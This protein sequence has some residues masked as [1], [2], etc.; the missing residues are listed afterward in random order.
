MHP[1]VR[2]T[3]A[4]LD[5]LGVVAAADGSPVY[6]F[7]ISTLTGRPTGTVYPLLSR[8][9][10]VGWLEGAWESEHH[11]GNGPRRRYYKVTSQG[12][13]HIAVALRRRERPAP[14]RA[15]RPVEGEQSNQEAG[16]PVSVEEVAR[17]F[18]R[19]LRRLRADAGDPSLRQLS[20]RTFYSP[21]ALSEAF[22]GRSIPSEKLLEVLVRA[23]GGDP[24]EW[25]LRRSTAEQSI[26][27]GARIPFRFEDF[28][29]LGSRWVRDALREHELEPEDIEDVTQETLLATYRR[30]NAI[31]GNLRPWV[32]S[33]ARSVARIFNRTT[34]SG[35]RVPV[36]SL[37]EF[38]GAVDALPLVASDQ[39]GPGDVADEVAERSAAA[40]LLS[41]LDRRTAQILYLTAEGFQ[42]FEIARLLKTTPSA[43]EARRRRARNHLRMGL[44]PEHRR[45]VQHLAHLRE[46]AG[47]PSLRKIARRIGY[48]HTQVAAVLSGAAPPPTWEFTVRLV[49]SL[50]GAVETARWIWEMARPSARLLRSDS[51]ADMVARSGDAFALWRLTDGLE[52]VGRTADAA[53]VWRTAAETGNTYAMAVTAEFLERIGNVDEAETWLRKAAKA[54]GYEAKRELARFLERAGRIEEAIEV[55]RRAADDGE[56]E[57]N[58]EFSTLLDRAG[59]HDEAL[60]VWERSAE[61]GST[62]ATRRMGERLMHA[63]RLDQAENY[64]RR[65]AEAGDPSARRQLAVL[66]DKAERVDEAIEMWRRL[67]D[68]GYGYAV[69]ELAA[70]MERVGRVD[71]A[72][73]V[74][75]AAAGRGYG[76]AMQGLATLLERVGRVDEAVEVWRRISDGAT[77]AEERATASRALAR[78]LD[79]PLSNMRVEAELRAAVGA[80]DS[81][82]LLALARLLD[83]EG[84]DREAETL[85]RDAAVGGNPLAA[86][87]LARRR[88]ARHV[89]LAAGRQAAIE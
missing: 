45:Y 76:F 54:G 6:G 32:T 80:G 60:R 78:L 18:A 33:H 29:P 85:L 4:T 88:Q 25:A 16:A 5:V 49:S 74:W 13:E 89:Q 75:R 9:E 28:Y 70:L 42:T 38:D 83:Q 19:G 1:D 77:G 84:R 47:N 69:H 52:R 59:R 56:P 55:W 86:E 36:T 11:R 72:V 10:R 66:L 41:S 71:E 50:Q 65:A 31:N 62:S 61:P 40:H 57:A 82:S 21:A 7:Q 2:L 27:Y 81:L 12:R 79:K 53:G 34:G 15:F 58:R 22:S 44:T 20:A 63:G 51:Y 37:D 64:L 87:A 68:N 17:E 26:R 23:C 8:L 14:V 39:A 43:V 46:R 73:E 30:W 3:N 48:S 67:A 35:G 24:Q